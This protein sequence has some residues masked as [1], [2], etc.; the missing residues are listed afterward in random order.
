MRIERNRIGWVMAACFLIAF[1]IF[2]KMLYVQVLAN[3]KYSGDALHNRLRE[4]PIKPNRGIIYGANGEALAVSVEKNSIYI[5]PSVLKESKEY[6]KIVED[7]SK[8]VNL[9][10]EDV[11]KIINGKNQDFAWLK[12][13]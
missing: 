1:L 8:A 2:S 12:A 3:D 7:L 5:T 13:C 9:S 10:K 11:E 6:A 4:I